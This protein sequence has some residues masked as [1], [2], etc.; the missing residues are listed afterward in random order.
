MM[1]RHSFLICLS[2]SAPCLLR[3]ETEEYQERRVGQCSQAIFTFP[4][5][6]FVLSFKFG[7][8]FKSA[9]PNDAAWTIYMLFKCN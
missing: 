2:L 9:F 1:L 6:S 8:I 5:G 7:Y 3:P 4:S